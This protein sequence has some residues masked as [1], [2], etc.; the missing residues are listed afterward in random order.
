MMPSAKFP[1]QHFNKS[2]FNFCEAAP[3]SRANIF[4][5]MAISHPDFKVFVPQVFLFLFFI[6]GIQIQFPKIPC[7]MDFKRRACP[8][9]W[10]SRI[11]HPS[12]FFGRLMYYSFDK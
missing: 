2:G 7:H 9:W 5:D 11:P 4:S 1:S 8:K 3:D 10:R 12:I 6:I